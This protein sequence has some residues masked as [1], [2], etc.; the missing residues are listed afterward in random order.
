MSDAVYFGVIRWN[1]G[2]SPR[3]FY[4][5][6]PRELLRKGAPLV[7][8]TRLDTLPN[9]DAMVNAP[10]DHLMRV[11]VYLRDRNKLPAEDRGRELK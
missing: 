4:D 9:G 2:E 5:E 3:R 10:L 6:V 8:C 11:Y 1:G 7:Y